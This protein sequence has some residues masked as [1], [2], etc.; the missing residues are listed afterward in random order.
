[1]KIIPLLRKH[2][3]FIVYII[4]YFGVL[5]AKLITNPMPFYDWDESI[6]SQVGLEM[7][8]RMSLVPSW[9]GIT[10]LDKPPLVPLFYG[11]VIKLFPFIQ[12]EISVRISTLLLAIGVFI[13]MYLLYY[14]VVKDSWLPTLV[15]VITSITPIFLQRSQLGNIDVFLL[16]GWLGYMYFYRKYWL[17][18][19]FLAIAVLSKSLVGFYP[20]GI[21]G[22][23]FTFLL[24][25]KQI[26]MKEY[27]QELIKL[28]IHT[29]IL[30]MWYV[31]MLIFYGKAFWIQHIYESHTKRVTASI[32]SHFGKRTFYIDLLFEQ[33]GKFIWFA[34]LGF[35]V[36]CWDWFKKYISIEQF[37]YATF[38]IPWFLFLNVTKTK[39]FWYGYPYVPQ[40]AFLMVYPITLLHKK[41]SK[42]IY[43]PAVILILIAVLHYGFVKEKV[44]ANEYASYED[45]QRV[46]QLAKQKCSSLHVLNDPASRDA[47]HTLESMN[48]TI[49][50]TRWWGQHPSMVYYYGKPVEY[51]YDEERLIE[52]LKHNNGGCLAVTPEDYGKVNSLELIKRYEK[53][54]LFRL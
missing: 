5:S 20:V 34:V 24:V 7:L 37:L 42:M 11:L 46:A 41:F 12:P 30:L 9:Q 45:H 23:Y 10:W 6:Y 49:T 52:L 54:S 14:K 27:R 2:L 33:Y 13:L 47:I 39:I 36:L 28:M 31:I 17:S 48:L 40:F 16:L 22:I 15:V 35:M 18:L 53:M 38:L 25:T 26:K 29:G 50:T 21:M 3:P 8:R 32:E 1:M 4:F 51:I 19:L 43:L 44:Y